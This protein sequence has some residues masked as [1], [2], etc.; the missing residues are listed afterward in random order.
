MSDEG[1][2]SSAGWAEGAG[3]SPGCCSEGVAEADSEP[4]PLLVST[5]VAPTVDAS[6][7][8]MLS[9]CQ[10]AA[11]KLTPLSKAAR[12][13]NHSYPSTRGPPSN[14]ARPCSSVNSEEDRVRPAATPRCKT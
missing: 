14:K 5:V 6:R 7:L 3:S 2:G 8:A 4:I 10:L 1:A 12:A 11:I 9:V 13:L